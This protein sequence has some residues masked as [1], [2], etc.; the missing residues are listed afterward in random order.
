[1][2]E[3]G[4]TLAFAQRRHDDGEPA[5]QRQLIDLI[6]R[7]STELT[8]SRREVDALRRRVE[9]LERGQEKSK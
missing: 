3:L 8:R 6:N 2:R 9:R 1:M 5:S 7:V 4:P